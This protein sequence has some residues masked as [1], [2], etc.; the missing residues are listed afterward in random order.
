MKAMKAMKSKTIAYGRLRKVLV[1]RGSKVKTSGGLKA[2]D[3]YKNKRGK[4]VSKKASA[5][6]KKRFHQYLATWAK[7]VK[8]AR[9][10]LAIDGWCNVGGKT[11]KGKALY[12]KTMSLYKAM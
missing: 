9:K 6:G 2:S 8:L 3:L 11:S 4:V 10:S 12:A 7:A 5:Q 1:L